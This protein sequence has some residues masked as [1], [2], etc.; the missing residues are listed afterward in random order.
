RL[1]RGGSGRVQATRPH[2]G[3]PARARAVSR[4]RAR[5]GARRGAGPR[6]PLGPRRQGSGGGACK[7]S[8]HD[9]EPTTFH[10]TIGSHE[11]VLQVASGDTIRTWC[12]DSGGFDR[13]GE[14]ITDGGNPQTGPF[15]VEDAGPGDALSVRLD[16]IRPNRTRGV[17]GGLVAPHV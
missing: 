2:R 7:V 6:L 1:G 15:Y 9:F 14:E 13:N 10:V 5:R 11:P 3:D 16:R 17:T 8:V 4:A 12:V